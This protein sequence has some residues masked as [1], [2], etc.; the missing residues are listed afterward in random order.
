[1]N[2]VIIGYYQVPGFGPDTVET[3]VKG[4]PREQY[5][6]LE[7]LIAAKHP[8]IKRI[9]LTRTGTRIE[10]R[11]KENAFVDLRP[12][13][14]LDQLFISDKTG[15]EDL[16]R[17]IGSVFMA[18]RPYAVVLVH[19][20]AAGY[21]RVRLSPKLRGSGDAPFSFSNQL[22]PNRLVDELPQLVKDVIGADGR[23]LKLNFR[24]APVAKP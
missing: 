13:Q 6:K 4:K 21:V 3:P 20:R 16:T 2:S 7:E 14:T 24:A 19:L 22:N 8:H 23:D 9:T 18:G 15:S 5:A 12:G 17:E 11:T 1:M 10:L